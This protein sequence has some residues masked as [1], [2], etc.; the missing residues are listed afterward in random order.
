MFIIGLRLPMVG[1]PLYLWGWFLVSLSSAL[2]LTQVI[3]T[4][5]SGIA[6]LFANPV[7]AYFGKISYGLYV[8]HYPIVKVIEDQ[9]WAWWKNGLVG[10]PAVMLVT[11]ASY[12]LLERPCLRLKSRFKAVP[13]KGSES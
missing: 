8:W 5:N 9:K 10:V 7:L 2:I 6:S 3:V 11:L 4:P 12:H 1:A 13:A